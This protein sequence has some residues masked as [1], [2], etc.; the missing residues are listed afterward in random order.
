MGV[1]I[2]LEGSYGKP[3]FLR[4]PPDSD[5]WLGEI[6]TWIE[7]REGDQLL[8]AEITRREP[9]GPLTLF[10]RLHPSN[11]DLEV[12][13]PKPG[14]VVVSIKTSGGGPGL[15]QH[16]CRLL[17]EMQER[18][19][20]RWDPPNERKGTGD[21]SGYFTTGDRVALEREML[22]WLQQVMGQVLEMQEQGYEAI[23]ISMPIRDVTF[24]TPG[25]LFTSTGPRDIHW[26]RRAATDLLSGIDIFPWWDEA[27]DAGYYRDRA[28]VHMWS[29]VR[30]RSALTEEEAETHR[31]VLTL[32]DHAAVLDPTLS[33]PETERAE[34]RAYVD[35]VEP[36]PRGTIG[37]YRGTVRTRLAA[38]WS[39]DVPGSLIEEYD[40][41]GNWSAWDAQRT[42][43]L[44][45]LGVAGRHG[46]AT[47]AEL[48]EGARKSISEVPILSFDE[49]PRLGVAAF[50]EY[51]E[52]EGHTLYLTG[53]VAV[54]GSLAICTIEFSD[55]ALQPWAEAIWRSIENRGADD[56]D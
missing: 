30:W 31:R 38:G 39:I 2:Y 46:V 10:A 56:D 5:T 24:L 48:I 28:V 22:N 19:E 6:K 1:G 13:C 9:R 7:Q 45:S 35:E 41:E 32:L 53:R 15:H 50:G 11:E 36:A 25:A 3:G 40:E 37:Y 16:A 54:P 44:S 51:A 26:L 18:F 8:H 34:I 14:K 23:G 42:V 49:P 47:A 17:H 4:R 52:P 33:L 20:V 55:S 12:Q 29:D 43:Y 27:R 21:P